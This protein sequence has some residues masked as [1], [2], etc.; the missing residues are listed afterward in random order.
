M[1]KPRR[2]IAALALLTAGT[3]ALAACS[4]SGS[5]STPASTFVIVTA[6][7]PQSFSYETS[8]TGYEAAEFFTNTGSTLI[9][10]KYVAG[11]GG[12]ARHEDYNS[13][14]P[15]LAKSY[16]VSS[17]GLTYTFHLDTKAKSVDGN[18]LTA[19]DVIFSMKR[20]FGTATSIIPF[21]SAPFITSPTQFTKVDNATVQVKVAKASYGYTM[22]S[23]LSN[24]LYN[25]YDLKALKSHITAADPYAV[26]WTNTHA[27]YGFGA[28]KLVSYTPGE[29]MIYDAN[30]GYP[31]GEPKVKRIVQRVV[32]DA[33][34]RSQLLK[35]GSAQIAVQLRP[36]DQVALAKAKEA[37]IFTVPTNAWVYMPLLTTKGVFKDVNV[38]RAL[39]AAIPYNE[40]NKNVYAGRA[41]SN[42][43][44][45]SSTDPGFDGSGL[46][47]NTTDVAK[48]KSILAAAGYKSPISFTLTVNNSVPDLDETAVQIQSA[49]KAAG[50]DVTI[51]SVNSATFQAGL[52]AKTFEADLQRDYAVVQSPP[53]VLSLFYTPHSPVNFP[54]FTDSTLTNDIA[55]GNDAGDPTQAAAG[56]HWNAAQKVLQDQQPTIYINYVQPL[57][58]FANNVDG[59]VFRSDSVIDYS[60]LSVSGK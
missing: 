11:T 43:T 56:K 36:A 44:I 26:K 32:A 40:I 6:A 16:D 29:Q 3:F 17:D 13:F 54:D 31:L 30:P 41:T 33:G 60:Q 2:I 39:A 53:Y 22:L 48:A 8:A 38:R 45:L 24:A 46:K 5:A 23:L 18:A 55:A 7:Q 57:N 10:N 52:T 28:Y 4:S 42:S 27:D 14:T 49:V 35:S 25:I 12:Q 1:R 34:T 20:K 15:L 19:D 58:A 59:Y 47:A 21:A 51:N 9:R 50:F 37:Q